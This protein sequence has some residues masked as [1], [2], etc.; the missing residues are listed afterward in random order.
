M[1][2]R[3]LESPL[4]LTDDDDK[5]VMIAVSLRVRLLPFNDASCDFDGLDRLLPNVVYGLFGAEILSN[6][7]SKTDK[8]ILLSNSRFICT[9]LCGIVMT[10]DCSLFRV[11][12]CKSRAPGLYPVIRA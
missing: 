6:D 1:S 8:Y 11:F 10:C 7:E 5:M 4:R 9:I 3:P 12:H 2:R